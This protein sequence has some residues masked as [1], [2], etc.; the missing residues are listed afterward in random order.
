MR[1]AVPGTVL[2]SK[3]ASLP[4]PQAFSSTAC[5]LFVP[6]SSPRVGSTAAAGQPGCRS[7]A[8][9]GHSVNHKQR[10]ARLYLPRGHC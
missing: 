9:T 1:R 8:E 7:L 4:H 2:S 6:S 3:E 5:F 10:Q